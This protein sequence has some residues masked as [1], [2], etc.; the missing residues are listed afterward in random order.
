MDTLTE[1]QAPVANAPSGPPPHVQLIQLTTGTFVSQAV[2]VVAR[3]GVADALANGPRPCHEIASAVG[4]D[5]ETLYRLLRAVA[6]LGVLAELEGARFELTPVGD[7]LRA[8]RE[9]SMRAWATM[10]GL[11]FHRNA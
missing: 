5:P 10:V 11:P 1:R 7:L 9:G 6:D 8:D 4:A 3:L 2:S